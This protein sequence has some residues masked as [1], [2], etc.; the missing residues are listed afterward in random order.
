[1]PGMSAPYARIPREH[2]PACTVTA[3]REALER[4]RPEMVAEF[5]AELDAAGDSEQHQRALGSWW[6]LV[7]GAIHPDPVAEKARDQLLAGDDSHIVARP[8]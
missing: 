1:M 7:V 6:A 5:D 4:H 3:V 8:Y 2:A